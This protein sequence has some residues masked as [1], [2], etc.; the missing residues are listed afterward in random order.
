[1]MGMAEFFY[2]TCLLFEQGLGFGGMSAV[3]MAISFLV[4]VAYFV[5]WL[6]KRRLTIKHY[7]CFLVFTLSIVIFQGA[8]E[9]VFMNKT[10]AVITLSFLG[11]LCGILMC[12]PNK[13]KIKQT[14]API[15]FA[16]F[17]D[18]QVKKEQ[19]TPS[20]PIRQVDG[21]R[22]VLK[23]MPENNNSA[24]EVDFSHVKSVIKR[25]EYYNLT[26]SDKR[27]VTELERSIFT[28]ERNG[29]TPEIKE[30]VNDGL[31]ALLKIM[32]KYGV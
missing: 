6:V 20:V 23:E 2:N 21:E 28:A 27:Q 17:I 5:F 26:P 9:L 30:S 19:R 7:A 29:I 12:L 13:S 31:G 11:V 4:F 3:C 22:I 10:L 16:R 25:L 1:M 14:D 32:S 8:I 24:P 15:Q 18:E